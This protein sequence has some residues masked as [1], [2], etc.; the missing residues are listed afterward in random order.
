MLHDTNGTIKPTP[1]TPLRATNN[2]TTPAQRVGCHSLMV[3]ALPAN[4]GKC[5][6]G[7]SKMNKTTLVGVWAILAI[8]TNNILPSFS[9]TLS[10]APGGFNLADVFI[11]CD[12]N[13]D[14]V[15]VSYIAG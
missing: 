6:I 13:G 9:A 4:A 15:L 5:Y 14:G 8:P 12:N 3:E 11:D 10:Y 7:S 1:G 2:F